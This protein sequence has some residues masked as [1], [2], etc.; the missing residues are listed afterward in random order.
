MISADLERV[1]KSASGPEDGDS[2]AQ[3]HLRRFNHA[4]EHVLTYLFEMQQ[5]LQMITND[6][7]REEAQLALRSIVECASESLNAEFSTPPPMMQRFLSGETCG[8]SELSFGVSREG[9]WTESLSS[10]EENDPS[11]AE[12]QGGLNEEH[13][14]AIFDAV[15]TRENT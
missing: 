15:F 11:V 3:A 4:A 9:S 10:D 6:D 2:E 7:Q 8:T 13:L 14:D 5:S 12:G 1:R